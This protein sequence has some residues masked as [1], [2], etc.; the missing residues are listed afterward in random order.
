MV[1]QATLPTSGT[2][3]RW[4]HNKQSSWRNNASS[5]W[6]MTTFVDTWISSVIRGTV[7][8]RGG[9]TTTTLPYSTYTY[10]VEAQLD[11]GPGSEIGVGWKIAVTWS[12]KPSFKMAA[13]ELG[14]L[15][16]KLF[17]WLNLW[18][19]TKYFIRSRTRQNFEPVHINVPVQNFGPP[20]QNFGPLRAEFAWREWRKMLGG[21]VANWAGLSGFSPQENKISRTFF[22]DC[23]NK[24]PKVSDAHNSDDCHG[25]FNGG[26]LNKLRLKLFTIAL[27]LLGFDA[28]FPWVI[29]ICTKSL[30][31]QNKENIIKK[32][33]TK[34]GKVWEQRNLSRPSKP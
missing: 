4:R 2:H 19:N 3:L 12:G 5:G 27:Q 34:F 15:L 31:C 9:R 24:H 13:T 6:G 1:S 33:L 18:Q 29:F 23:I 20:A 28:F 10:Q 21:H 26:M 30:G 17:F 25:V 8:P 7:V 22:I 32:Q 14:Y 16:T 11:C